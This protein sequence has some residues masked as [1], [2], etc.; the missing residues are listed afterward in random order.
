MDIEDIEGGFEN[1]NPKIF[2]R[3]GILLLYG[4]GVVLLYNGVID[5]I[6]KHWDITWGTSIALGLCILVTLVFIFKARWLI[7]C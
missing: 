5:F 3:I 4:L 7:K 2:F 1:M 6:N